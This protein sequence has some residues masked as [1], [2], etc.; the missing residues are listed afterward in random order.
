MVGV[1]ERLLAVTYLD[2]D[3]A[4]VRLLQAVGEELEIPVIVISRGDISDHEAFARAGVPA[5]F[6]WR[7][8]N[9]DYH[10]AGDDVVVPDRLAEDLQL[11]EG[12]LQAL[13]A[14]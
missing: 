6:L 12:F 5:A 7:P 9:P 13:V 10:R 1:G 8:D 4:A 14:G 3:P 11:I 2:A